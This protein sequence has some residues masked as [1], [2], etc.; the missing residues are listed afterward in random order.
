MKHD[1][2][3]LEK[4]I[5]DADR[6]KCVEF[7]LSCSPKELDEAWPMVKG[8]IPWVLEEYNCWIPISSKVKGVADR[9]RAIERC[10]VLA[11]AVLATGLFPDMR[12][13]PWYCDPFDQPGILVRLLRGVDVP[14]L[15]SW[16]TFLAEERRHSN[17]EC[18]IKAGFCAPPNDDSYVLGFWGFGRNNKLESSRI[19]ENFLNYVVWKFFELEGE[20]D[21][22]LAASDKYCGKEEFT[23]AYALKKLSQEGK[24]SLSRLLT[25]SLEALARDF[26][27]F[28]AGWHSRFHEYLEP[29][30]EQRIERAD[31][32]LKLLS[33]TIPP[34]VSFALNALKI[35]YDTGKLP[36]TELLQNLPPVLLAK[37]KGT[38]IA[39]VSLLEMIAA[40]EPTQRQA[41]IKLAIE[42]LVSDEVQVQERI[43]KLLA[44]YPGDIDAAVKERL[45]ELTDVL[46]PSSRKQIAVLLPEMK[47]SGVGS[48]SVPQLDTAPVAASP[49]D[50]SRQIVSIAG[51]EELIERAAYL[52]ENHNDL[53]ETERVLDGLVRF[54]ADGPRSGKDAKPLLKRADKIYNAKANGWELGEGAAQMIAFIVCAW[55]DPKNKKGWLSAIAQGDLFIKVHQPEGYFRSCFLRLND[56]LK[57]V[58]HQRGLPLL[59]TP[60]HR[61][62]YIDPRTLIERIQVWQAHGE[63]P[64]GYDTVIAF[65]RLGQEHRTEAGRSAKALTGELGKAVR[66]A[67][68]IDEK[69]GEQEFLWIAA[70]RARFGGKDDPALLKKYPHL[71][72]GAGAMPRVTYRPFVGKKTVQGFREKITVMAHEM[73]TPETDA[74]PAEIK[75]PA[76]LIPVAMCHL[77]YLFSRPMGNRFYYNHDLPAY[78][79][80][81]FLSVWPTWREPVYTAGVLCL[82]NHTRNFE[83]ADRATFV[84]LDAL[85]GPFE[86]FHENARILLNFGFSCPHADGRASA[87]NAFVVGVASGRLDAKELG[88]SMQTFFHSG[89]I[90]AARVRKSLDEVVRVSPKHRRAVLNY[91]TELLRGD[92]AKAPDNTVKLLELYHELLV[93][94]EERIRDAEVLAYLKAIPGGGRAAKLAKQMFALS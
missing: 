25:A 91:L 80:R 49:L 13:L 92:P 23:W 45:L 74:G 35:I 7:L 87:V 58:L 31:H 55:I 29:T 5:R 41:V 76:L 75:V 11:L 85:A 37:S 52:L 62:F 18:L 6:E 81:Y 19:D 12:K 67:C 72:P 1:A 4:I 68:G 32:Y 84:L 64:D 39:A 53:E 56:I 66:Y 88:K 47:P 77:N 15:N 21:R 3:T 82:G 60:T 36:S 38:V 34:T 9:K 42:G 78:V 48:V 10:K 33:S 86:Q 43:V 65:L 40:R 50:P 28:R 27:Q 71:G 16:V 57:Q 17:Y 44:K 89:L 30:E 59:S 63:E 51:L 61:D 70:A 83:V 20:G 24:L 79:L 46:S 22:S 2:A 14:W 93:E 54:A 8:L 69:I 26:P 73:H 94:H 90:E